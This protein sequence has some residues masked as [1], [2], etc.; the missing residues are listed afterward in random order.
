MSP[1]SSKRVRIVGDHP[2]RGASGT[3][4]DELPMLE[5]MWRVDLDNSHTD[6]CYAAPKNIRALPA[7]E[8][9]YA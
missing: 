2:H 1:T 3:V 8:D 9:P 7:S 6:S 5:G 4:R